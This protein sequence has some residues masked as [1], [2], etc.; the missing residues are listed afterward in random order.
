MDH[1]SLAQDYRCSTRN[2]TKVFHSEAALLIKA[3]PSLYM[4][5][6]VGSWKTE[7]VQDFISNMTVYQGGCIIFMDYSN[8]SL[9][10]NYFLLVEQFE[11]ISS[12]LF[13]FMQ[14][15]ERRIS[16]G[17]SL[18]VWVFFRRPSGYH[19]RDKVWNKVVQEIKSRVCMLSFKVPKI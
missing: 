19:N 17:K 6:Y 2:L 13:R 16:L 15:L 3:L 4:D 10:P 8:V 5:G 12:I 11:N 18:H 7:W 14:Q 1:P 9:N